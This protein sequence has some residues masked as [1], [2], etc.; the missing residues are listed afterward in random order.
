MLVPKSSA[1]GGT[2]NPSIQ[3]TSDKSVHFPSNYLLQK[4]KGSARGPHSLPQARVSPSSLQNPPSSRHCAAAV[5]VEII[6]SPLTHCGG[7]LCVHTLRETTTEGYIRLVLFALAAGGHQHCSDVPPCSLRHWFTLFPPFSGMRNLFTCPLLGC[8]FFWCGFWTHRP[9]LS[10]SF[11][12]QCTHGMGGGLANRG[13]MLHKTPGQ[14]PACCLGSLLRGF[15]HS[16]ATSIPKS[17][18]CKD[19]FLLL[20]KATTLKNIH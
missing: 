1:Q 3:S 16:F 13:R 4:G 9:F 6:P 19:F 15:T 11:P 5:S 7:Q 12:F 14:R 18:P 10:L 17:Q 2:L 8:K 20:L